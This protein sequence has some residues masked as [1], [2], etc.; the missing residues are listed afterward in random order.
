[1]SS[2]VTYAKHTPRMLWPPPRTPLAAT[3]LYTPIWRKGSTSRRRA[4]WSS[5][6]PSGSP[7]NSPKCIGLLGDA[8]VHQVDPALKVAFPQTL[9]SGFHGASC[10]MTPRLICATSSAILDEFVHLD[11][12]PNILQRNTHRILLLMP[13]LIESFGSW[14]ASPKVPQ[15]R[16]CPN[17]R[18]FAARHPWPPHRPPHRQL[19]SLCP[20]LW[21]FQNAPTRG[22]SPRNCGSCEEVAG[23]ILPPSPVLRPAALLFCPFAI[24]FRGCP[25][26]WLG[27]L[28]GAPPSIRNQ[29]PLP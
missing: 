24:S 29:I 22:L 14:Q 6:R 23:I 13:S 9:R 27:S 26:P 19:F 21:A 5:P 20:L 12:D 2:G 3:F 17:H 8:K 4:F 28:C 16:K 25:S 18:S 10:S 15:R 11:R 1:M 7:T